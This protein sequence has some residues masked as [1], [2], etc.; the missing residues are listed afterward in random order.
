MGVRLEGVQGQAGFFFL[1]LPWLVTEN[2][3]GGLS[4]PSL[5]FTPPPTSISFLTSSSTPTVP[6][7]PGGR[8]A[9][10]ASGTG[11]GGGRGEDPV[12]ARGQCPALAGG[13]R[14]P[15]RAASRRRVAVSA[16]LGQPALQALGSSPPLALRGWGQP[17]PVLNFFFF[18]FFLSLSNAASPRGRRGRCCGARGRRSAPRAATG[19]GER[20]SVSVS[21]RARGAA[22]RRGRQR[23][24]GTVAAIRAAASRAS[25]GPRRHRG[26]SLRRAGPGG[27]RGR[28]HWHPEARGVGTEKANGGGRGRRRRA[29]SGAAPE[30]ASGRA[31]SGKVVRPL[32]A[33]PSPAASSGSRPARAPGPLARPSPPPPLL[34]LLAFPRPGPSPSPRG[35]PRPRPRPPF[36]AARPSSPGRRAEGGGEAVRGP[37]RPLSRPTATSEP[38]RPPW[39][40]GSAAPGDALQDPHCPLRTLLP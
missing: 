1:G 28:P 32:G 21:Y 31:A 10:R 7:H 13:V 27:A 17:F 2:Q 20:S 26:R 34:S 18:S 12:P 11:R 16:A 8:A 37:A 35:R 24:H 14:S 5:S 33:S 4:L 3:G 30:L 15:L 40:R 36:R 39:G 23:E 19:A 6:T 29:G 22:G 38:R 9:P 25:A